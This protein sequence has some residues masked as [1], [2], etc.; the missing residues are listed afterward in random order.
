MYQFRIDLPIKNAISF[1]LLSVLATTM[2][3]LNSYAQQMVEAKP[4]VDL[5]LTQVKVIKPLPNNIVTFFGPDTTHVASINEFKNRI[6]K[7]I[8]SSTTSRKI[9]NKINQ[10]VNSVSKPGTS[11]HNSEFEKK[12]EEKVY[13]SLPNLGTAQVQVADWLKANISF[14]QE[15]LRVGAEQMMA[16]HLSL[17]YGVEA[18]Q[19]AASYIKLDFQF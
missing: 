19:N 4:S 1:C 14:S 9:Q 8:A 15:A 11:N 7:S 10:V 18:S 6:A 3:S 17:Q 13:L 12:D 2:L 5:D 16:E